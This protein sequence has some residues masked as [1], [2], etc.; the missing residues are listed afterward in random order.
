MDGIDAIERLRQ[1]CSKTSF[2]VMTAFGDL[3]TAVR[4]VEASVYEYLTKP[5]DLAAA[6]ACVRRCLASLEAGR[7]VVAREAERSVEAGREAAAP[8]VELLGRSAAMQTVFQR[9]AVAA[10]ADCPVLLCGE[11][12]TGKE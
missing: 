10:M 4:A 2:I 8:V 3:V 6:L 5:F 1:D 7:Q 9:V 12:G 11:S